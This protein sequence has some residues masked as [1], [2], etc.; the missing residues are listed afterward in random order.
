MKTLILLLLSFITLAAS[1]QPGLDNFLQLVEENNQELQAARKLSEAEK[2]GFQTELTPENPTV[3]YGRFPGSNDAMGTKT[4]YGISQSFDFPTV[5][6][7]RKKLA[8]NR[9]ELSDM[10]YQVFRQDKLLEAKLKFY[11]YAFLLKQKAEYENRL[12]HSTRLYQSYQA[13]FEQGST[14]VLDV[15]KARI[16]NLMIK[17][18]YQLLLQSIESTVKELE[19]LAGKELTTQELPLLAEQELPP[20]GNILDEIQARQPELRYLKQAQKIAD[21]NV[22]L[23][24]NNWLPNLEISYEGERDPD[25]TYRG[26]KAGVAIPL[27]KD[28]NKV[29]YAKAQALY[30]T[31]R[32]NARIAAILNETSKL[33][34]QV[35]EYAIIR[36]EYQQTLEESANVGFLDKALAL[37][38]MS[39]ID[40]FNELAFYYETMDTYLEIEK[41]YYQ[42]MARLQAFQL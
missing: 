14:S 18:N 28:K 23:A 35:K 24:R 42:A 4:V 38:E 27:W 1:A 41:N 31:N 11:D 3:E 2:A 20:L 22:K 13:R 30:E 9:G 5:Y 15:N 12:E 17:S 39:V 26:L 21:M 36:D 19:L 7:I 40:Y 29:Q 10:E 8:N 34:Q 25:G 6:G 16:Q 32:Y 33:Y 37:G